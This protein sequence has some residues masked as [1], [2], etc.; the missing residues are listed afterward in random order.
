[1]YSMLESK[2]LQYHKML[3]VASLILIQDFK[4]GNFS[5]ECLKIFE[6]QKAVIQK[7]VFENL[8]L[9]LQMKELNYR[10]SHNKNIELN[11]VFT[12][13]YVKVNSLIKITKNI[14][15]MCACVC[16]GSRP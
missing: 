8:L 3:S 13:K 6:V 9:I 15:I 10:L 16:V 12:S 7:S 4:K 11:Q 2:D 14:E 1:M 5:K